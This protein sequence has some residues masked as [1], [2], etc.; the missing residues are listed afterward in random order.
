MF[1]LT[2]Y[3]NSIP[4]TMNELD[5][6]AHSQKVDSISKYNGF[7]F[8]QDTMFT[9]YVPNGNLHIQFL[10]LILHQVAC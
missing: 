5:E 4:T 6:I 8:I 10:K 9:G 1:F 2:L 3:P 7:H